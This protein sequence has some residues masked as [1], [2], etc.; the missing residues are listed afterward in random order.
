MP[1]GGAAAR[2]AAVI[3]AR[4]VHRQHAADAA[5]HKGAHPDDDRGKSPHESDAEHPDAEGGEHSQEVTDAQ[6]SLV[7]AQQLTRTD[8]ETPL[9]C[10]R[11]WQY[12]P[13]ARRI[14]LM[15]EVQIGVACLIAGNFLMNAAQKQIDPNEDLHVDL[16]YGL[17]LFFNIAF[18]IELGLNMYGFWFRAFWKSGWNIFDFLVVTIGLLTTFEVPLPG[19]LSM[20]RMMRAFRVFRLFKRVK[21]L[22]KI[23]VSLA[24]AV[25]GMRDAFIILLLVMCIYAILAVEFFQDEGENFE[26]KNESDQTVSLV[27]GRGQTFGYEY[28]G[29]FLKALYTMFQVLTGDSWSEVIAR[30]LVHGPNPLQGVA[31]ASFFV[32][33]IIVNAIVLINVVVAVLLEKMV[34]DPSMD[35]HEVSSVGSAGSQ[36]TSIEAFAQKMSQ[37]A[38]ASAQPPRQNLSADVAALKEEVTALKGMV[39]EIVLAMQKAGLQAH[40]RPAEEKVLLSRKGDT[41]NS[42]FSIDR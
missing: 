12:Q 32:S 36:D 28:F 30:P 41:F 34:D 39:V 21:S 22:N 10:A 11:F 37:A 2:A 5:A 15:L 8:D 26:I 38:A 3:H 23:M 31:Y 25:P 13:Q 19:P 33:F 6:I 7:E 14:Y 24:K 35:T 1:A 40:P 9:Y 20:L 16:W 42:G 4:Q 18:T 17:E 27:T 29:N